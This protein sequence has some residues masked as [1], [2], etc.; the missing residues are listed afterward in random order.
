MEALLQKAARFNL[1]LRKAVRDGQIKLLTIPPIE[2]E[3]DQIAY[4][5]RQRVEKYNVQR[6]VI[7]GIVELELACRQDNRSRSYT[8]ALDS[9]FKLR[10]L[11]SMYTYTIGKLIGAE[12]DLSDTV[13][14]ALSEN[15][16][17][18][19]QVA[20]Q[21]R[22]YRIVSVLK[23]RDSEYDQS[24][25]EFIINREVGIQVLEPLQSVGG[26]LNGMAA[27]LNEQAPH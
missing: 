12:L 23:M 22:L 6:V 25:R 14:T 10:G 11:T 15:L 24:I 3:P 1:N 27:V 13:F 9:Y 19:R 5:I 18:L 2:L 21:S 26:F 7:D 4:Y 16:I 8:S 20:Y 17:L